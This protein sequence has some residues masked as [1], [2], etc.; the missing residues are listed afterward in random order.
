MDKFFGFLA[1]L[2]PGVLFS[3]VFML[4]VN[5]FTQRDA[6]DPTNGRSG[7]R[8][9]TDAETGCQ[10]LSVYGGGITARL[11]AGGKQICNKA[12]INE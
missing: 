4:V 7:M 3:I 5:V 2:I 11:D 1:S 9:H 12:N 8:L 6:T 10:Y